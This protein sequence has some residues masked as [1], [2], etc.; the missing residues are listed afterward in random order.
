MG[1][2]LGLESLG[3]SFHVVPPGKRAYP[4]H[5]HHVLDELFFIISGS[6]E[7]R[8]GDRVLPVKAGDCIGSP[9]G[10]E[11][12]QLINT[13]K[14]EIRYL[15]ISSMGPADILEYPDSGKV[16]MGAGIQNAD[17]STATIFKVGRLT[18]AGYYDGESDA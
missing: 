10:G 2:P 15:A 9:A 12:H 8:I 16:A 1:P 11:A 6:G 4:F 7:C 14:E 18:P 3:C 13:G 17:F 5:R